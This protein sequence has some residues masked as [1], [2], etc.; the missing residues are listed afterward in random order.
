MKRL[1]VSGH[2]TL[3]TCAVAC[4][5]ILDT[6]TAFLYNGSSC[7]L[8]KLEDFVYLPDN[9]VGYLQIWTRDGAKISGF[10]RLIR[11][12]VAR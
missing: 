5:D 4:V 12:N 1:T 7:G 9:A 2:R 11:C 10:N 8:G 6:C 3:S